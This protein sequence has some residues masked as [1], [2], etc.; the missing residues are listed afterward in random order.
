MIKLSPIRSSQDIAL[1]WQKMCASMPHPFFL[2]W[3]WIENVLET[4]P[5]LA[6]VR[7]LTIGEA[8]PAA[9]AL[10]FESSVVRRGVL[11]VKSLGL[12][13][14]GPGQA[15]GLTPE[16]LGLL[17]DPASEAK[18]WELFLDHLLQNS[19]KWH[20]IL[21]E[22]AAPRLVDAWTKRGQRVRETLRSP[23]RQTDLARVRSAK[24]ASFLSMIPPRAR[25]RIRA[26]TR[27]VQE[28]LGPVT[29]ELAATPQQADQY[30]SEFKDLHE[31]R[32]KDDPSGGAFAADG[33]EAF[34]RRL[35]ERHYA[36]G[37]LCLARIKAGETT[38]GVLYFF[39]HQGTVHFYQCG[40][41]YDACLA[42]E[43]PGLLLH[44][45]M[46]EH[47]AA[48]GFA[49]YDFMAGDA[50]YKRTLA[51]DSVDL[52]W[53]ALQAP[54]LSLRAEAAAVRTYHAL[55]H[56]FARAKPALDQGA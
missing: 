7:L 20:E 30:F 56:R 14:Q 13:A 40:I 18:Y 46:I 50:Q 19:G 9:A 38:L 34:H 51:T 4:S 2:S 28:R 8:T 45:Q 11:R 17:V 1:L 31:R 22:G 36:S 27:S 23:S 26:T 55:R 54:R 21:L 42:N 25:S 15:A 3:P 37:I 49:T 16:Y 12:N 10:L 44:V 35:I 33:W 5:S 32:W 48:Q 41:N 53:G 47:F 39:L 6:G 29:C 43:S 24:D 52:W